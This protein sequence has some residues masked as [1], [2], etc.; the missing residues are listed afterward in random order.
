MES[1]TIDLGK[2]VLWFIASMGIP[3]AITGLIVWRWERK[4]A[5]REK[6]AEDREKAREALLLL[7]VQSTGAAI[8][9]GEATAKAVQRIPDAHC[10]GDMHEALDYAAK[11]KHEQKDFLSAQGIHAIQ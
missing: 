10:N 7:L 6:D 9:L 1:I 4:I 2:L 11:I 8:A 3:S 5:K